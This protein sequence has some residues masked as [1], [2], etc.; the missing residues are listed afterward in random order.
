MKHKYFIFF[1]IIAT[2]SLQSIR[3]QSLDK[4]FHQ[5]SKCNASFFKAMKD[6]SQIVQALASTDSKGDALWIKVPNRN[7]EKTGTI[8]LGGNST[9]AGLPVVSYVDEASN[10]DSAGSFY[11][12]G[13][14]V[15]GKQSEVLDKL[16]NLVHENNR[17][18]KDPPVYVRT[19]LNTVGT[20]WL[21]VNTANGVPKEGT[22]ERAFLFEEDDK[23]KNVTKVFCSLQGSVK[24]EHLKD[25]RPDIDV[26]DYPAVPKPISFEGTMAS[27]D[28][29]TQLQQ[30][31]IE[32]PLFMPKFKRATV[33]FKTV[34]AKSSF[35][36]TDTL[37]HSGGGIIEIYEDLKFFSFK[38]QSIGGLI[39]TKYAYIKP[40]KQIFKGVSVAREG[41]I[42]VAKSLT[43]G[44]L[45]FKSSVTTISEPAE[46]GDIANSSSLLCTVGETVVA[47]TILQSLSGQ[48]TLLSCILSGKT[49]ETIG[50]A[51][52]LDLGLL[53]AYELPDTPRDYKSVYTSITIDR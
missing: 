47:S 18:R 2:S 4:I 24:A 26:K 34:S 40:D 13:F 29:I 39:Q 28:L 17:L 30:S 27:P 22:V 36:Q 48:A 52:I 32:Q 15:Q 11:F 20:N 10:M 7:D 12:W 53:L 14:K 33:T 49:T 1:A 38:R 16:K 23:D 5:F 31:L 51:L 46:A 21:P 8:L 41:T 50:Y 19:E 6:D 9:I 3:A 25:L 35:V 37:I 43:K 44:E 45:A 42:E